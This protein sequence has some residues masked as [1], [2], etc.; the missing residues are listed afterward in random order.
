MRIAREESNVS[1]QV[2]LNAVHALLPPMKGHRRSSSD[3]P[4]GISGFMQSSPVSSGGESLGFEKPIQLVL[5]ASF[6]DGL[7]GDRAN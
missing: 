3:S 5:K 2:P 6:R 1:S 4:L 7:D